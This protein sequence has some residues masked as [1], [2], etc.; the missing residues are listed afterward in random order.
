[1]E[2]IG[3][4]STVDLYYLLAKGNITQ[5]DIKEC[6]LE[7]SKGGLINFLKRPF[8]KTRSSEHKP[9]GKLIEEKIKSNPEALLIS[10][11]LSSVTYNISNCCSPIPGDD[12]IGFIDP[13][14]G[15]VIHRINCPEAIQLSSKFGDRIVKTKWRSREAIT[16]LAGLRISGIDRKGLVLDI[17]RVFSEKHNISIK[18]FNIHSSGEIWE[19]IL[20]IYVQD[21]DKLKLVINDLKTLKDIKA[22]SRIDRMSENHN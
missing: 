16:F 11:D 8:I 4:I 10:D 6:F 22:I 18:S 13:E 21:I 5:K 3:I 9:L 14:D 15:I 19:A 7:H 12:V 20:M 17:M 2:C 1:M